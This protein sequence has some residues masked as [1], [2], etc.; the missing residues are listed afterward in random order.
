MISSNRINTPSAKAR[1]SNR[2][3]LTPSGFDSFSIDDCSGYSDAEL[4]TTKV[5]ALTVP[6][7]IICDWFGGGGSECG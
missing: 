7:W 4:E 5:G 3:S 1:S 6:S 2:E